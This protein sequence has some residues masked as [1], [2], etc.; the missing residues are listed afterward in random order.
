MSWPFQFLIYS[1][2]SCNILANLM[3]WIHRSVC[4]IETFVR[5]RWY[6][7][8]MDWSLTFPFIFT[9]FPYYLSKIPN[10]YVLKESQDSWVYG[11]FGVLLF[12][13]PMK[14]TISYLIFVVKWYGIAC[15][16]FFI[17]KN[18]N[19][20][21]NYILSNTYT[22]ITQLNAYN[23]IYYRNDDGDNRLYLKHIRNQNTP[24][25]YLIIFIRM[26][27]TLLCNYAHWYE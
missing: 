21:H 20:K 26:Y 10:D 6:I 23:N 8:F 25:K 1:V 14:E 16:F 13:F 24:N 17:H 15:C 3:Q 22:W 2:W 7:W 18:I 27:S 5:R 4:N 11:V 12:H 19:M 9:C